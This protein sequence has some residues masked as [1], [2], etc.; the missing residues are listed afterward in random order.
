[1]AQLLN[2]HVLSTAAESPWLNG[3]TERHNAVISDIVDR[4]LEDV[5]CSIEVT[6]AWALCAKNSLKNVFGYSLNQLVFGKNPNLPT[7]IG[8]EPPA[9]EGL[10]SSKLIADHLNCM[11]TAREAF[12]ESEASDKLRRALLRKTR[13]AT[14]LVYE[15]GDLVYYKRNDSK[16]WRGPGTVIGKDRN[17]IYVKHGGSYLRVNPCHIRPVKRNEPSGNIQQEG[18]E[19]T[20]VED[21]GRQ[22]QAE[23][24][25]TCESEKEGEDVSEERGEDVISVA[26]NVT[27][28]QNL[29]SDSKQNF[30]SELNDYE[31]ED[32]QDIAEEENPTISQGKV[33][34]KRN[35]LLYQLSK[36]ED[37]LAATVIGRAGQE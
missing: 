22:H 6:P 36:A 23:T 21:G 27:Q 4:I 31:S 35:K 19:T 28:G 12:I 15:V 8:S 9:L 16:R 25:E 26:P 33:S 32:Q 3:I 34:V 17:Q 7:V 13:T 14:S 10:S 18:E 24:E 11:H 2:T 5:N 37:W 20:S 1:M 29:S 30:D